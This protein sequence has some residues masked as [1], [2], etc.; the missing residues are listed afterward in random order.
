LVHAIHDL[1]TSV[2]DL[3]DSASF[4][5]V[6]ARTAELLGELARPSFWDD[7]ERARQVNSAIY[8]LSRITQR[9]ADLRLRVEALAEVPTI[10]TVT[11]AHLRSR[12][13]TASSAGYAGSK[14]SLDSRNSSFW[15][16]GALTCVTSRPS[17][18]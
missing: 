17:L 3:V 6:E 11:A 15:Q 14:R 10:L 7:Q 4:Q 12:S 8:Q 1:Q 9:V 18:R 5:A 13:W 2:V 16:P